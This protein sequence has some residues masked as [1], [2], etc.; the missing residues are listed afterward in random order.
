MRSRKRQQEDKSPLAP[1]QKRALYA[2]VAVLWLSGAVWL[3]LSLWQKTFA[4]DLERLSAQPFL[5]EIH[6]AAAMV[7][8]I[9]FGTLLPGHLLRGWRR[10]QERPS[11]VSVL[12]VSAVMVASGWG[13][14]YFGS[15]GLRSATSLV[16]SVLGILLP[17]AIALHVWLVKRRAAEAR[18]RVETLSAIPSSRVH[19]GRS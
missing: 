19:G 10:K 1:L 11:G 4:A 12:V 2:V 7:F 17:L 18:S 13:L 6:G 8:L 5:L 9:V 15:E 3:G 14:Y 16:H